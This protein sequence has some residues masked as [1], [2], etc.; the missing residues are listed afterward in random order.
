ME[1]LDLLQRVCR[2]QLVFWLSFNGWFTGWQQTTEMLLEAAVARWLV[3]ET[4][5]W[6][7]AGLNSRKLWKSLF[8]VDGTDHKVLS[9]PLTTPVRVP[10]SKALKNCSPQTDQRVKPYPSQNAPQSTEPWMNVKYHLCQRHLLNSR[11]LHV[12]RF[13]VFL[14]FKFCTFRC[15]NHKT[16]TFCINDKCFICCCFLFF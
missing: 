4:F 14:I 7:V 8:V 16:K 9:S 1:N 10:I 13:F 2:S 6:N 12:P 15:K 5:T 3:E 11:S